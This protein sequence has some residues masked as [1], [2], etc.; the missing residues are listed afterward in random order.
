[1]RYLR[2]KKISDVYTRF[3]F[4]GYLDLSRCRYSFVI[5]Q[6]IWPNIPLHLSKHLDFYISKLI[7]W[8]GYPKTKLRHLW[9][10]CDADISRYWGP[11]Q[12]S[13][14]WKRYL[15]SRYWDIHIWEEI[16][17][18]WGPLQMSSGWKEPKLDLCWF[19]LKLS[20]PIR[21]DLKY[22]SC[23]PCLLFCTNSYKEK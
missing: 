3:C 19:P 7:L 21:P 16:S 23:K 13:S 15:D 8:Q 2:R 6:Q 1:M 10:K 18:C 22:H 9:I 12:M 4:G 14:G 5:V 20:A 11:V 17:R